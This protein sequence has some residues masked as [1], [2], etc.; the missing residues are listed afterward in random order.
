MGVSV[1]GGVA[2]HVKLGLRLKEPELPRVRVWEWLGVAVGVCE[3]ELESEVKERESVMPGEWDGD[4]KAVQVWVHV[5]NGDLEDVREKV[6]SD[7]GVDVRA[8][9]MDEVW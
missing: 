3:A 7:V 8:W 1:R 5:L 9:V 2:R 6:S 4:A